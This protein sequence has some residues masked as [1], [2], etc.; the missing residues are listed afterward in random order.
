MK[1]KRMSK[2]G[3]I[4]TLTILFMLMLSACGNATSAQDPSIATAV[5]LTVAA[6]N[7]A[8]A[9]PETPSTPPT[10]A[11]T[12]T[13]VQFAPTLT[14]LA[15][16]PSPTRQTI[17]GKSECAKAS[18]V[19]ETIAD[20]TIFR[21]GEQFTK[22]WH[23]QNMSNCTWTTSYKILFWD[24]DVLGGAYVYNL[25]QNTPPQ[26]IV[27]ISLVLTAPADDN[28]YESDWMLQTPD[29]TDFGVG[30]YNSPFWAKIVVSNAKHPGYSITKVEYEITRDPA[31]G[32]PANVRWTITAAVTTSGPFEFS[33]FW[34]Q[35]DGNNSSPK[36][37]KIASAG[38]TIFV[39][40]VAYGLAATPGEKWVEFNVSAP[41]EQA[42]GKAI[43]IKDCGQP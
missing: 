9:L 29:G 4:I 7:T 35:K 32:C 17:K 10:L 43:F 21:P 31:T 1:G 24:G 18:L 16:I 27:P 41:F 22:T 3:K 42:Y 23:I 37:I 38:T 12:Q 34:T 5:A 19:D 11:V 25:P 33:Y 39:R 13:P 28:T 14:P 8:Q 40:E 2:P 20:G 15:A 30:E 6:Q 26:G 36:G